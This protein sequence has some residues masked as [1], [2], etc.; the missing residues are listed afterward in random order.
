MS[1]MWD[2]RVSGVISALMLPSHEESVTGPA[3]KSAKRKLE[4]H[5][6]QLMSVAVSGP[7]ISISPQRPFLKNKITHLLAREMSLSQTTV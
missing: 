7:V 4:A 3:I 1:L 5:F 2:V 6:K